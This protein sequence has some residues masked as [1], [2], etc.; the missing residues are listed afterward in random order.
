MRPSKDTGEQLQMKEINGKKD[1]QSATTI[2]VKQDK[3]AAMNLWSNNFLSNWFFI[4]VFPIIEKG[5]LNNPLVLNFKLRDQEAARL[6]VD[7][8][9]KAWVKELDAGYL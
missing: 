3:P 1:L 7:N 2:V 9:E 4:W 5:K 6:N 8:L